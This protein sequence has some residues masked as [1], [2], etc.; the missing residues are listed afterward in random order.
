[1]P[2]AVASAFAADEYPNRPIR[3]IVP[4]APGGASD[5]AARIVEPKLAEQF[6]RASS[7]K[8]APGAS[9]Y[10]AVEVASQGHAGQVHLVA[11][12]HRNDGYQRRGVSQ[13]KVKALMPLRR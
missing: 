12:Q 1:V 2:A 3:M 4:F 11:T 10:L 13:V 6:A 9:G 5:F 7:S 8:I